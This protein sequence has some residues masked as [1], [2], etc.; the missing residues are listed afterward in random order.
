MGCLSLLQGIFPTQGSNPGLQHCRW[1]LYQLSHKSATREA[2]NHLVR[3]HFTKEEICLILQLFRWKVF[4]QRYLVVEMASQ[5]K[6]ATLI[7]IFCPPALSPADGWCRQPSPPSCPWLGCSPG[8]A[9][10]LIA[11]LKIQHPWEALLAVPLSASPNI[12]LC[13]SK[14]Y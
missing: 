10:S 12:A 1:I 14:W 2:Q 5:S 8:S 11:H 6:Q 3:S 13:L 9:G 7:F 4:M